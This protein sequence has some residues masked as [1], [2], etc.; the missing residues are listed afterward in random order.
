MTVIGI[1]ARRHES[2]DDGQSN[3]HSANTDFNRQTMQRFIDSQVV[4]GI[5]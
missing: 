3:T 4:G 2:S 1:T 5:R